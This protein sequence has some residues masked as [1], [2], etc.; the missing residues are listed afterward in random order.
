[1]G[2]LYPA[3]RANLKVPVEGRVLVFWLFWGHA[4]S[5]VA[6][7]TPLRHRAVHRSFVLRSVGFETRRYGARRSGYHLVLPSRLRKSGRRASGYALRANTILRGRVQSG[8]FD[9]AYINAPSLAKEG[10]NGLF[11][12]CYRFFGEV[13]VWAWAVLL[14]PAG[15]SSEGGQGFC[16]GMLSC[17]RIGC[18][19]Y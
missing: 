15:T 4:G 7:Q 9:L 3:Q 19:C 11:N 5:G 8:W 14:R 16:L 1:M 17:L 12:W 10:L 6:L 13:V 18:C 2:E